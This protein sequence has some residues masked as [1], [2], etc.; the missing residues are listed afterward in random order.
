MITSYYR[1]CI[2]LYGSYSRHTSSFTSHFN[3]RR[4]ANKGLVTN[5]KIWDANLIRQHDVTNVIHY[6]T[7]LSH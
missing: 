5:M 4:L 3:K 7:P 6:A 2:S 1:S